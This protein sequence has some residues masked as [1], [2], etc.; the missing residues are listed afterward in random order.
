LFFVGTGSWVVPLGGFE[1]IVWGEKP[2]ALA[3][4][5]DNDGVGGDPSVFASSGLE[6]E[7]V[8]QFDQCQDIAVGIDEVDVEFG[9]LGLVGGDGLFEASFEGIAGRE[10]DPYFD[11]FVERAEGLSGGVAEGVAFTAGEVPT[12]WVASAEH[13]GED[14]EH[15]GGDNAAE[16]YDVS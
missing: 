1:Q 14:G 11:A 6:V 8:L 2:P 4:G 12:V 13:V 16:A 7:A 15:D 3:A 10:H 9:G 5:Y